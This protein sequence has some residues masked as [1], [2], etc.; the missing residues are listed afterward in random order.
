[1]LSHD[2]HDRLTL[3]EDVMDDASNSFL[4]YVASYTQPSILKCALTGYLRIQ[5]VL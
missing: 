2:H 5:K 1:M 4:H 3:L